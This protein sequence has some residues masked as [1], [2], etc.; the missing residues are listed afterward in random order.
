M[1]VKHLTTPAIAYHLASDIFSSAW[2][3]VH[4]I[5]AAKHN[6]SRI[7]EDNKGA[8]GMS[9]LAAYTDAG[10]VFSAQRF[11]YVTASPVHL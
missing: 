9:I 8:K 7:V 5:S 10:R 1:D 11:T 3:M 6:S 2:E 4:Y